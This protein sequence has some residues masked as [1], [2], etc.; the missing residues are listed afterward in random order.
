MKL[1]V[2]LGGEDGFT[3]PLKVGVFLDQIYE[4]LTRNRLFEAMF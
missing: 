2:S 4:K 1:L 3:N